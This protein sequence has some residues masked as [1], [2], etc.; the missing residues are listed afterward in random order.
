MR[1]RMIVLLSLGAALVCTA[2]H[3]YDW[4]YVQ[5]PQ[6]TWRG[7]TG[8]IEE[9]VLSIRPAGL[10]LE[11]GLYL[12]FSARDL[13]FSSTDSVEVQFFFDLPKEAIVH[14]LWLW[15]G[16]D[17][18]RAKLLDRWTAS[19]IYE[20]I[21]RRR[22]D[23]AILYKNSP[24]QYE[25][26]IYP[27]KGNEQRKIKLT[28]L[29]PTQWSPNA[30]SSTLPLN[31]I[32]TSYNAV[33]PLYLLYWEQTDWKNP[34]LKE[35]PGISFDAHSDTTFGDY[36]RADVP[37]SS[38]T[39]SLSFTLDSPMRDGVF[40]NR[41]QNGNEGIYQLALLPSQAL[42]LQ[43][44]RKV[45]VLF[46]YEASKTDL[47]ATAVLN[48]VKSMLHEQFTAADSFNLIF[49]NLNIKRAGEDW[50]A[51]DSLSIENAFSSVGQNPLASYSNLPALLANAID[52]VKSNGNEGFLWLISSSDHVGDYRV[53]NPLIADLL[54]AMDP[55]PPIYVAD[56]SNSNQQYY[57]IGNRYYLG[58]EYFYIN[59]TQRTYGN[60]LNIR[61]TGNFAVLLNSTAE[62]FSGFIESFDLYTTLQAG[63]CFGR[64]NLNP[65]GTAIFLDRPILQVGKYNGD[66]P[67]IVQTSGVYKAQPFS[68]TTIVEL[69]SAQEADTLAAEIWAGNYISAL[70]A[71]PESNEIIGQ[72]INASLDERVLSRYTAFLALEPGDTVEVCFDCQDESGVV[73]SVDEKNANAAS[74]SLLLRAYP[75]PFNAET[76]IN[77]NL[78]S[79]V[80]VEDMSLKI[81]NLLGQVV[82]TFP[83]T[84]VAQSDAKQIVWDGRNEAGEAVATGIYYVIF[85]TPARKATLKLLM[86]K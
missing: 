33:D 60:Y 73:I 16:D 5:H 69:G 18:V 81:Y 56:Y 24:T 55:I 22:R 25:L 35:F 12:T 58:N 37:Y 30:V 20:D 32:R 80:K 72:I 14:D 49:S 6:Q 61:E 75:N 7:G 48:G 43:T 26:R 54:N 83:L 52:F 71:Q 2:A 17:I 36:L 74:D 76:T 1:K 64:F 23:P 82:R 34:R 84:P 47:S 59:L 46:D 41:S 78:P 11:H 45:A 67:F 40:V 38:Q 77:L 15:V 19:S 3:A 66:F 39:S 65:I 13:G 79:G 28:Y 86:V 8:T 62:T 42:Q 70:E 68:K 51:G 27:M 50:F 53:A 10:Y 9:A 44:T 21:V 4:L 63:F 85:R 57:Y 29:A 31:L